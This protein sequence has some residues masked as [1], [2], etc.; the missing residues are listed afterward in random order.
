MREDTRRPCDL[1]EDELEERWAMAF[2]GES[3][4]FDKD[5]E[6]EEESP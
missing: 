1:D 4:I 6:E 2:G 3:K 5:E